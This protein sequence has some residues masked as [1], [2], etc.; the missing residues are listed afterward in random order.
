MSQS[1]HDV[2]ESFSTH[3][4][5]E[6]SGPPRS[7]DVPDSLQGATLRLGFAPSYVIVG[8]YRLLSDKAL[9]LPVW[10]MC[11]SGFLRGAAVGSIWSFLT[12]PIQRGLIRTFWINSPH[13]VGHSNDTVLGFRLPFDIPTWA[14]LIIL[15]SQS[16][17][18]LKFFLSHNLRNARKCAWDLTVASRGKGPAFWQP[19]VEEWDQPPKVNVKQ[20]AGLAAVKGKVLR[21]AI[22]HSLLI[23][24]HVI[25]VGGLIV[26]AAIKALNTAQNL[27]KPYFHLKQMTKEQ[28]AVFI[29]EHQWDYQFFGFAAALLETL[30]FVGLIFSISNQVG[31]AMWAH[32]LE[33]RQHWI[34][35][36]KRKVF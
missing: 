31:A 12:F 20:W 8:V 30:P 33:K 6:G 13:V 3:D 17:I 15:S 26:I 27:H 23:F 22:K 2:K 19:Y 9:F 18:V 1:V 25:P 29:A 4:L 11:Q 24:L 35:K 34:R 21:F 36:K 14:T 16:T 5:S 32:D 28:I 7:V 10:H